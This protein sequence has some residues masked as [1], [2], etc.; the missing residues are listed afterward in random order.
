MGTMVGERGNAVVSLTS[1]PFEDTVTMS[2]PIGRPNGLLGADGD[3]ST[4]NE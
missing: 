2:C 1:C 4:G 3:L